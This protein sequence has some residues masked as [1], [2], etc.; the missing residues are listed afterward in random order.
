MILQI[1]HV[2]N[3]EDMVLAATAVG[4]LLVSQVEERI[5]ESKDK[6]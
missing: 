6:I 3:D 5:G 2:L 1:R 4:A